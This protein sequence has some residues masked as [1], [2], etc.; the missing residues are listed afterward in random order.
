[1]QHC[2]EGVTVA[3]AAAAAAVASENVGKNRTISK[4]IGRAGRRQSLWQMDNTFPFLNIVSPRGQT[5][6]HQPTTASEGRGMA[7]AAGKGW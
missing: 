5:P 7:E 2:L 4:E 1:M 3:A 6:L